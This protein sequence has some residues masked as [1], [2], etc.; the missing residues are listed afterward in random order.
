MPRGALRR[1]L[2][3]L[4]APSSID[5][6]RREPSAARGSSRVARAERRRTALTAT[7]ALLDARRSLPA[8]ARD[9]L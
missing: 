6:S 8:L 7:A 9:R 5:R 3:A 4:V 1:R 2:R